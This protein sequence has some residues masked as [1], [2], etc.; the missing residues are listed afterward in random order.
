M[1]LLTI[2]RKIIVWYYKDKEPYRTH[3]LNRKMRIMEHK[4]TAAMGR[5]IDSMM[6]FSKAIAN[7]AKAISKFAV[8]NQLFEE[9]RN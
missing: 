1:K 7:T 9:R 8:A 2:K 3:R 6:E 4:I 5:S